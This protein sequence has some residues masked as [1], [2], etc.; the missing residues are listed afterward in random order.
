MRQDGK[1]EIQHFVP[2]N[3]LL[4]NFAGRR[5]DGKLYVFD[6]HASRAIRHAT[7]ISNIAAQRRF[8]EAQ[9]EQGIVSLEAPLTFIEDAAAPV[10]ERLV[11]MESLAEIDEEDAGVLALFVAIQFIRVPRIREAQRQLRQGL[12]DIAKKVMPHAKNIPELEKELQ[13]EAIKLAGL[14]H[15][16]EASSEY[17]RIL[18]RH[19]WLLMKAPPECAFWISDCPVVLHNDRDFGPY[20]NLGIA[21]PA[22]QIYMPI[23]PTLSLGIWEAG[24]IE[25]R[26]TQIEKMRRQYNQLKLKKL[27]AT[28]Q[29]DD[30]ILEAS[31]ELALKKHASTKACMDNGLPIAMDEEQVVFMNYLQY[32]WSTR[33]IFS[34]NPDFSLAHGIAKSHPNLKSGIALTLN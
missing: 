6:K 23:S 1:A 33:F 25:D 10:I 22:I 32:K 14:A 24:V 16:A 28:P 27:L 15:I 20:G 17:A 5:R 19:Q 4:K 7:S 13:N 34:N 12:V 21:L 11:A 9:T 2:K 31:Y 30:G 3:A 26:L 18:L 29:P 8:N